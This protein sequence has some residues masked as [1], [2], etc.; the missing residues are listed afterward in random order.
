MRKR[1]AAATLRKVCVGS[2]ICVPSQTTNPAIIAQTPSDAQMTAIVLLRFF[3][4]RR[5]S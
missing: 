5:S 4:T 3:T 1:V 2:D